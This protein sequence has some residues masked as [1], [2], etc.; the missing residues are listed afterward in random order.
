MLTVTLLVDIAVPVTLV[1]V[2]FMLGLNLVLSE[3]HGALR[4]TPLCLFVTGLQFALLMPCA[5]V[6]VKVLDVEPVL[7][8]TLIAIAAAPGGTFSNV[9]TFLAGGNLALSIV[10]TIASTVFATFVSPV[11]MVEAARVLHL[12]T[13]MAG[14]E[15]AG[16][17]RDLGFFVLLPVSAGMLVSGCAP[18]LA[19]MIRRVSSPITA[20]AILGLIALTVIV[21]ASHFLPSLLTMIVAGGMLTALSLGT[22]LIVSYVGD[23]KDRSSIVIEFGFRNLPI[24]LILLGGFEPDARMVAY[25]L[26]YFIVS[27][28]ISLA[29]ILL[30]RDKV[31]SE[32]A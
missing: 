29:V 7:A 12:D 23:P 24:A 4:R 32:R 13:G 30:L 9:L 25:L 1:V 8:I 21:S 15:F 6:V 16:V 26:S 11:L 14:L 18:A 19:D 2:M 27:T 5:I 22:G 3:V 17:A 10:L 28:T 20:A 31:G